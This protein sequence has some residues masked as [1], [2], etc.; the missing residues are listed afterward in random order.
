MEVMVCSQ[1][2][3]LNV[4]E[5]GRCRIRRIGLGEKLGVIDVFR[6]DGTET[7]TC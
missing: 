1:T 4:A 2:V 3:A 6:D 5:K 7:V